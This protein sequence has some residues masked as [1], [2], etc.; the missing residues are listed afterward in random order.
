MT[1]TEVSYTARKLAPFALFA[2]VVLLIFFYGFK[3]LFLLISLNQPKT[4]PIN[5]IFNEIQALTPKKEATTSAGFSFTLDTVEGKPVTATEAA[6]VFLIPQA[7]FQ[8][9]YLP[10]VY[11]MA[12]TVGFDTDIT[13]HTLTNNQAVFSEDGRKLSIDINTFNFRYDYDFRKNARLIQSATVPDRA[14]MESAAVNFLTAINRY[15]TELAQG[16]TNP[17]YLFY[18]KEAS[19]A[20]VVNDPQQS[21]MIEIDFYRPDVAQFPSVSSSYFNSPNYVM[22]MSTADGGS[23]VVSAQINF[24]ERSDAQVGIYPLITG[25]Q[26]YDRLRAGRGI[27]IS[28][29]L[30]KKNISVQKIF[31]GYYDPDSYQPYYQPVYVFLGDNGFVSYVPAVADMYVMTPTPTSTR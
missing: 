29:T 15:P 11:A 9:D 1:L 21:N 13:K 10:T 26:A 3:L 8:F 14:E 19:S 23:Q 7:K 16:K 22:L 2:F 28:G 4:I 25:Q 5:P 30:T 27:L 24:F 12:K 31:L 17:I 20:S 18:D 6:Q